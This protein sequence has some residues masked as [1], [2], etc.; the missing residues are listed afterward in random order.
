MD[1]KKKIV[2]LLAFLS[3]SICL[4]F[5]RNT[6]A[7][8]L[9]KAGADVTG[10][11]ARWNIVVNNTT[12]KNNDTLTNAITPVFSGTT[13]IAPNVVAPTVTGYFDLVID[14]TNVDV[15]YSYNISI[16]RNDDLSDFI[17][18]GY[19]VDSGSTISVDTS[20]ENPSISDDILLSDAVRVHTIRVYIGWNDDPTTQNMDNSEDTAVTV[21]LENVTLNVEMSFVQKAS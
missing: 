2:L 18:T 13:H 14:S 1:N 3:L 21:D 9:T 17:V 8:Y 11:I 12:V 10:T 15:S 4:Y 6:Y 19:S 16:T 5:A 7:K 20:V